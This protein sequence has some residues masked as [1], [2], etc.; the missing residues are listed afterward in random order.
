M[1]LCFT[2]I[3]VLMLHAAPAGAQGANVP[4]PVDDF[5]KRVEGCIHFAGEGV[6]NPK[7][8]SEKQRAAEIARKVK[9]LCNGNKRRIT[10]LKSKHRDSKPGLEKIAEAE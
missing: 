7:T 10:A 4:K 9:D 1:R 6:E 3:L 2:A 8:R 5:F